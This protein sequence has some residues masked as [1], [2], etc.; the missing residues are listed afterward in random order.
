[1]LQE[2]GTMY[3]T[4]SKTVE[5]WEKLRDFLEESD[6]EIVWRKT[7]IDFFWGRIQSRYL[8]PIDKLKE[9]D[10]YDGYGFTIMTLLCSLIEFLESTRQ[11]TR[12]RYCKDR[13]LRSNEYNKSKQY[14]ITFLT[15]RRPFSEQFSDYDA[16]EFYSAIRCGLLHEAS[17][18]NG[19]KVWAKSVSGEDIISQK[20]KTVYRDDF[21]FAI[22]TYIKAYGDALIGNRE[23]QAAFIRK[24]DGLCE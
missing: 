16:S 23:L 18:K 24:Y 21:E 7:F 22:R 8:G 15:T 17:T 6:D 13:D 5:D 19:W 9:H 20:T 12:Y 10:S 11:G 4:S 1:M 3:L 2:L 14:F